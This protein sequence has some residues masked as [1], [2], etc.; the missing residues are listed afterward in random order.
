[1]RHYTV[2][3]NN[4]TPLC[5]RGRLSPTKVAVKDEAP[6]RAKLV[7]GF[8]QDGS[9]NFGLGFV[10]DMPSPGDNGV[11]VTTFP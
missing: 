4:A 9:Q 2:F 7:T 3:D 5:A 10:M 6:V 11:K 1:M 8:T